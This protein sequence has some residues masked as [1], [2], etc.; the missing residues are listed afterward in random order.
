LVE[1]RT[2]T[3][4][5]AACLM[6]G[7]CGCGGGEQEAILRKELG[8]LRLENQEL[9]SNLAEAEGEAGRLE[10]QVKT[11]EELGPKVRAEG[12]YK[13][14]A[15]RI[16]RYTGLFDKDEDG[17]REKLIVYVQPVDSTGDMIKAAGEVDVQLWDLNRE[18]GEAL[19]GEWHVSAEELKE[20]W[21][22]TLL[23]RNYRLTFD[24]DEKNAEYERP[25][26][27]K[28]NFTDYLSGKTFSEQ[29]TIER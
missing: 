18:A 14:E 25:L 15:V 17:K 7:L 27:V 22:D 9:A 11:L 3:I 1:V 4:L 28:V 20:L 6:M 8:A 10:K 12:L 16:N 23:N 29:R 26:T 19:L 2:A 24:I 5:I 13:L 21:F